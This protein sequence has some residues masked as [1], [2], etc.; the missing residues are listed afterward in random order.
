[1]VAFSY[2]HF[3]ILKNRINVSI[4]LKNLHVSIIKKNRHFIADIGIEI[5]TVKIQKNQG[6]II[7]IDV[8]LGTILDRQIA[9]KPEPNHWIK[10]AS[11]LWSF[12]SHFRIIE[13]KEE[14]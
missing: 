11:G 1:V 6:R 9:Q 2:I 3:T 10:K 8:V 7:S 5:P 13:D 12:K 14:A 4:N